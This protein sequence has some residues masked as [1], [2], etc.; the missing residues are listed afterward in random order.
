MRRIVSL[1]LLLGLLTGCTA[2]P[3]EERS[4]AVAM[5]I[6]GRAGEWTVLARIPTYQT[7]GGYVT[8]SGDGDTLSHALAALDAASPMELHPGQLRLV[9]VAAETARSAD[10]PEVLAWLGERHDLRGS[11]ALAVTQ[12]DLPALMETLEPATGTRLSKSLDLLL[13]T[14]IQQGSVLSATLAEVLRMGERQQPA[15]MNA[16]LEEG[17]LTLSGSWPLGAD[18]RV[19]EMLTAEETRLLALMQ[20]RWKQ[21]MLS[22]TEGVVRLT[23]ASV[24]TELSWPTLEM[25]SVRL[26]LHTSGS[27][28]T[29]DALARSVATAC[30]GVL[31]RLSAMGCDALGLARQAVTHADDM[32]EWHALAWP[33][34]YREMEWSVSVGVEGAAR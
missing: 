32:A 11:A 20:G 22:L 13:E 19:R 21:G 18:G 23:D 26:T 15:L 5:G 34:K 28:L 24:E 31:G 2:L 1:V 4:F 25:A 7:G 9:I 12:E 6:S 33:E 29:E 27:P 16:A 17:V 30:L 10:F 3:A 8:V 14:R